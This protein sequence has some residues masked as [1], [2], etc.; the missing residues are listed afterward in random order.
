MRNLDEFAK[1]NTP[2]PEKPAVQTITMDKSGIGRAENIVAPEGANDRELLAGAGL[3]PDGYTITNRKHKRWQ[4]QGE[5]QY[6]FGFDFAPRTAETEVDYEAEVAALKAM[7]KKRPPTAPAR[8]TEGD[9]FLF[10]AADWQVGKSSEHTL[11]YLRSRVQLAKQRIKDLRKAGHPMTTGVLLTL[12]DLVEGCGDHY[13]MQT[14]LV[15]LDRRDQVKVARRM[16]REAVEE[17]APLFDRFIVTGIGGNHGENRKDG[18]AFTTFGD[19][20]DVAVLEML[21]EV[22]ADRP[23]FEH[24]E[25]YIPGSELSATIDVNGVYLGFTHGHLCTRG[26]NPAA[27]VAT[28]W[29]GQIMGHHAVE[30]AHLLITGHYHHLVVNTIGEGRSHIQAPACDGGSDWFTNVSGQASPDGVLTLRLDPNNPQK[31]DDL[32]CL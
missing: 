9:S 10:V 12:G 13:A 17:L 29:Q 27:K 6:W 14:F 7:F 15:D 21:Q 5:W 8:S 28:W 23:G 25:F 31:W 18:K 20:D 11:D 24:V 26:V 2:L 32:K 16:L 30:P 19:N 1:V 4:M 22:L 3:D